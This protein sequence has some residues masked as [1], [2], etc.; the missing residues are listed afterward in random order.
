MYGEDAL[1][2]VLSRDYGTEI[3]NHGVHNILK[4]AGLLEKRKKRPR[5]KRQLS[6]YPYYSGEV[7][8]LD[9]KH[10]RKVGFQYD[11][12]DCRTRIKYK[13]IYAGYNVNNTVD[14]LEK[15][16]RFY[17]PAFPIQL[18]QMDN[19]PEFTNERMFS[20]NQT[21][22]SRQALPERWL[23]E[24]GIAFRHIPPASPNLNGRI[25]RPHGVDKWR[26]RHLENDEH[27]LEKLREFCLED[28]LDYNTYRPHSMLEDKTP[29]EFLNSLAGFENAT[30]DTSVLD[31]W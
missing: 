6:D 28:C 22:P 31:V 1:V 14:F 16:L 11:I 26:F 9:V 13:R 29:V 15:A 10:W 7:L 21:R 17:T 2:V 19:G 20:K 4:R 23:L 8:Q 27:T 30:I 12:I 5:I 25:E 3:S 24:H 18:V